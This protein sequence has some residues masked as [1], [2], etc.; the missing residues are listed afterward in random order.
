MLV[1]FPGKGRWPRL[2]TYFYRILPRRACGLILR[3]FLVQCVS[4]LAVHLFRSSFRRRLDLEDCPGDGLIDWLRDRYA[5]AKISSSKSPKGPSAF[6]SLT[7]NWSSSCFW[8]SVRISG[9]SVTLPCKSLYRNRAQ[10]SAFPPL[11]PRKQQCD[12]GA[13]FCRFRRERTWQRPSDVR[14]F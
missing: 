8:S 10:S 14:T 7:P 11:L 1:V 5:R 6:C 3:F 12:S 2:F 13:H 4:N 9:L